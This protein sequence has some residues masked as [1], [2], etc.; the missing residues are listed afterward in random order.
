MEQ[1]YVTVTVCVFYIILPFCDIGYR[2]PAT[3]CYA[4]V[5]CDKKMS[6]IFSFLLY[7]RFEHVCILL[8]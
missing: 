2:H 6:N 1:N 8:Q 4:F 5:S 3:V 7:I